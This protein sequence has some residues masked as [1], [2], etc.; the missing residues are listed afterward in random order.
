[1]TKAEEIR[2]R[3]SLRE[4]I[5]RD[6]TLARAGHY[7]RGLCPFHQERTPSFFIMP[8]DE[9][10][11]CFGCGVAGD[12]IDYM[13]L[14]R[15][16]TFHEAI[17]QLS[18]GHV[19]HLEGRDKPGQCRDSPARVPPLVERLWD[20]AD[21][22]RV[23]EF[24]L[25]SRGLLRPGRPLS[26]ALRGHSRVLYSEPCGTEKPIVEPS[27]RTWRDAEGIWWKGAHKP[28]ML[29]AVTDAAGQITALQ[30]IWCE[31]RYVAGAGHDDAR[32]VGLDARKKTIGHLG[33]GAVR[34]MPAGTTLGIA[35]GVESALAAA[36]LFRIPVWAACGS[37]RL[38]KVAI[39]DHVDRVLVFAD[40]GAAGEAAGAAAREAYTGRFRRC[41]IMLPES[42]YGDWNDQLLTRLTRPKSPA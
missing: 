24:Y 37:V 14:T 1:M 25:L 7:W 3:V 16:L 11:R 12:V 5:S 38:S 26:T 30:R 18:A 34:L 42:V 2:A 41:E 15:N 6:V 10:F 21:A 39:P 4:L 27:W 36:V 35:E 28:A 40:R 13:K 29:A 23:A 20:G 31:R 22:P 32:A 9:R 19:S 17:D 8:G 33:D